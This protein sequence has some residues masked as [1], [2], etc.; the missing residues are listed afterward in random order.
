[1]SD[2]LADQKLALRLENPLLGRGFIKR[3]LRTPSYAQR[4]LNPFPFASS[5]A[6]A[7][8]FPQ[9]GTDMIITVF[10]AAVFVV[11][12][13]NATN[14]WT[15]TLRDTAAAVLATIDTSAAAA[16]TWVRIATAVITQPGASNVVLTVR[17]TATLTPGAIF[18]VPEILVIP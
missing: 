9:F 7:G 14:F 8:E 17:P 10:R 1:M 18:V 16:N 4:V 15:L 13:N 3:P 6:S 5:G 12:T 2:N 11:T